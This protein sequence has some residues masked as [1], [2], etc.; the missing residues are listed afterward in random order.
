MCVSEEPLSETWIVRLLPNLLMVFGVTG[1]A[2]GKQ[3]SAMAKVIHAMVIPLIKKPN[4]P[5]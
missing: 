3:K 1:M 4:L 5:L 2:V